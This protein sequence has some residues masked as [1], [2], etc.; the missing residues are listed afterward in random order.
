MSFVLVR[1]WMRRLVAK[2]AAPIEVAAP[3][4]AAKQCAS[5]S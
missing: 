5:A 2:R 3:A 4:E 1:S